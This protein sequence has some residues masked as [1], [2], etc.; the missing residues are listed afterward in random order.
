MDRV[1]VGPL[2]V[3]VATSVVVV[4]VSDSAPSGASVVVDEV[5]DDVGAALD[6][7]G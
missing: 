5:V 4:D 7:G 6:V 1:V 3:V 2:D